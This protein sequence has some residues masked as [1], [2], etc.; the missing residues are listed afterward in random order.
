[1]TLSE[2]G[3]FNHCQL[4]VSEGGRAGVEVERISEERSSECL[5]EPARTGGAGN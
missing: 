1:V 2:L 5:G 3:S 4:G